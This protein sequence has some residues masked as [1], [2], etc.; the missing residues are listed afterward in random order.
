MNLIEAFTSGKVADTEPIVETIT[1]QISKIFLSEHYA[2]KVYVR[3]VAF[4]GNLSDD[5]YRKSFYQN[6]FSWNQFMS[7]EVYTSLRPVAL[8]NGMYVEVDTDAAEDFIIVMNKV[9]TSRTLSLLLLSDEVTESDIVQLVHI[10]SDKTE[11][12]TKKTF[13]QAIAVS[14]SWKY[15]YELRL[16]D[17]LNFSKSQTSISYAL[18]EKAITLLRTHLNQSV[19]FDSFLKSK[20]VSGIDM[21][22]DNV[23]LLD[24]IVFLD[25]FLVEDRWRAIDPYYNISRLSVDIAALGD[26]SLVDFLYSEAEE[27]LGL[28]PFD[29]RVSYELSSA[30]LKGAYTAIIG[31]HDLALKYLSLIENHI[32]V[33]EEHLKTQDL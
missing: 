8:K 29:V 12:L 33:L 22:S 18:I 5:S 32:L 4:F 6:D 26:G 25:V 3:H 19:Y 28:L 15:L 9:D 31:K 16:H 30:I 7:S 14:D 24:D 21:H 23:L 17:L 20:L 1:T 27:R 10:L 11:V 13:S 2:Y